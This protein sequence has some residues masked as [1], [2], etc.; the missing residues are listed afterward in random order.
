VSLGELQTACPAIEA[1][2]AGVLGVANAVRALTSFGS[3]GAGAVRQQLDQWRQRLKL[4][5]LA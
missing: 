3:G 4:A 5:P 2:V 1:G